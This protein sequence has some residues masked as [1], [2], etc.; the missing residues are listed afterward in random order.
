MSFFLYMYII[1]KNR[2]LGEENMNKIL[3]NKYMP[4]I[5]IILLITVISAPIFTM[6]LDLNNEAILH[7]SRFVAVDEI[8][9][10]GIFPPIINYKFMEGFG[11]ALNLF[12]GPLTTYI[13]I[14]LLNIFKTA[15]MAFKIFSIV[16]I[17]LSAITMYKF[18]FSVTKR[19]SMS[20]IA[21]LIYISVPYK[22]SNIYSRNAIGEYTAFIFIPIVFEGLYNLINEDK[23]KHYLLIIGIV[24][25]V[26]SHTITTIYTA[27]FAVIYL[28]LNIKKLKDKKI[29]KKAIIDII[30][31]FLICA[32]YAIPL[33]EHNLGA[34]YALFNKDRMGTGGESV[35]STTLGLKELFANE[36]G[37]QEIR[38]SLGIVLC[39]LGFL[40]IFCLKKVK[41]ENEKIYSDFLILSIISL[42]M[43]TKLFPWMIMPSFLTVIQFAWRNIGFFTFFI[44]LVCGINAVTFAESILKKSLL[45]EIFLFG[46]IVSIFVFA[47][48][49]VL[50]D[51]RF[52]DISKENTLDK[53]IRNG[54]KVG[55]FQINREYLPLKAIDNKE[56]LTSRENRTY[57]LSG[58]AKII[59]EKKEKLT[60]EIIINN[61]QEET[62]LELPFLYYLGYDVTATYEDGKVEKLDVTESNNGFISVKIKNIM[63]VKINIKYTGTLLE[64]A[65]YIISIIGII[66]SIL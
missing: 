32:F 38:F 41:K 39:F 51:F 14:I 28:I 16:T 11:Y 37:N 17:I 15:G 27:L 31:S 26:L 25:L 47:F 7:M 12:Y 44:S 19:K 9:K 30:I 60:N 35:Y 65:S 4:Y 21:A 13:P 40:T 33:L 42:F 1:N 55:T 53:R 59:S 52:D 58:D 34:D 57:I 8:I 64:K 54:E 63:E 6:N 24:G 62:V 46:V 45:K 56:Y 18:S 48:L 36:V 61:L 43:C 5:L 20:L 22:L 2:R 49:G 10:D 3:K 29:W 66:V 50:R 23:K